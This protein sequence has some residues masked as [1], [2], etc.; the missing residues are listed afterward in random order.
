MC[1]VHLKSA[2]SFF[3]VNELK[4]RNVIKVS[5]LCLGCAAPYIS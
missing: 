5:A 1:W 4:L 3:V 2:L